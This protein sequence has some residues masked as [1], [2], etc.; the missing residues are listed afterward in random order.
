V[1][2]PFVRAAA[3][4]L[5]AAGINDCEI[6]R[7]LGIPR[8]TIRDWRRPT[9]VPRNPKVPR[10][11]CPRCWRGAKPLRFTAADY[12]ELLGLYLGDGC[13]S[14]SPRTA[15]L[16]ITLDLKYP[17]IISDTRALVARCFPSNRVD[18]QRAGMTGNCVNVSVYSLHLPCVF[19]QHGA[20][21]KHERP[22]VLEDW[23]ERLVE[24]APWHLLRGLIR[25]DGSAFIN[26]TDVHRPRPYEY[27]SYDF[28][29]RSRGIVDLFTWACELVGVEYRRTGTGRL[30]DVRINRRASVAKMLEH[31]GLKA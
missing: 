2:P 27:L 3:L 12:C 15:R 6:S 10:E 25:S 14:D 13:I 31:V 9:Y 19:P 18:V 30:H 5:I 8:G 17:G 16:R 22:I 23:Q 29:N 21:P 4:E 28:S 1:H 20:G 7:R 24:D 11:V 26:R